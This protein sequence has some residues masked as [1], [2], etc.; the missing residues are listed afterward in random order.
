M[1]IKV[2]GI[3][4]VVLVATCASTFVHAQKSED[5]PRETTKLADRLDQLRK[6]IFGDSRGGDRTATSR[7]T[8]NPTRN[9]RAGSAAHRA[10]RSRSQSSQPT[11]LAPEASKSQPPVAASRVP[12]RVRTAESRSA[13][14]PEASNSSRTKPPVIIGGD[15]VS[16]SN[17]GTATAT[18]TRSNSSRRLVPQVEAASPYAKGASP[19]TAVAPRRTVKNQA[20]KNQVAISPAVKSQPVKIQS[21]QPEKVKLEPTKSVDATPVRINVT[22]KPA[23]STRRASSVVKRIPKPDTPAATTRLTSEVETESVL[24]A[25][26]SPLLRVETLGPRRIVVGK[27]STY[28]VRIQN[29]GEV[30][31]DSVVVRVRLPRGADVISSKSSAGNAQAVDGENGS[32]R[33]IEW[34]IDHIAGRSHEQLVVSLIPRDNRE[35]DLSVN[36]TSAASSSHARIE[37][38]EPKLHLALDGPDELIYG[39]SKVYRLTVSN[40]GTGDADNVAIELMPIDGGDKPA[41]QHKLG[42]ILAGDSK[43]LEIELTARQAGNVNIHAIVSGDGDLRSEVKEIVLVR[44]AG[45]KVE[46]AGPPMKYSGTS[47]SYIVRVSNPGNATADEVQVVASLPSGVTDVQP[48]GQGRV[49][50]ATG[51]VEWA[52]GPLSAGQTRQLQVRYTV[53]MPGANVLKV[54]AE[55]AGDVADS[56]AVTTQVEGTADLKLE[57]TDPSGPIAVG[58]EIVYLVRVRNRGSK[59]ASHVELFGFFSEGLEP[60]E[61]RQGSGELSPGQVVFDEIRGLRAGGEKVFKIVAKADK[62]GNHIFHAEVRCKPLGTRLVAEESTL[63]Y[64]TQARAPA[65][66]SATP[67]ASR[68]SAPAKIPPPAAPTTGNGTTGPAPYVPP[69]ASQAPLKALTPIAPVSIDSSGDTPSAE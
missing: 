35:F 45:L 51:Q 20:V 3:T 46:V 38:Q 61:V 50:E 48:S 49:D 43:V 65:K 33:H 39:D 24:F 30:G 8:Q 59:E 19:R 40:P 63:F 10:S 54:A 36:W 41:A 18:T 67:A 16:S 34:E 12:R 14:R 60:I 4:L 57:V 2:A 13:T 68:P 28:K 9:A 58:E 5:S 37:V 15:E 29:L 21:P 55:T 44:R 66:P 62:A 7:S 69:T 47:G 26:R 42:T 17:R 1:R 32:S 27:A 11:Q 23:A 31:A 22:P 56:G 52:I 25:Q 64:E 6:D 53:K